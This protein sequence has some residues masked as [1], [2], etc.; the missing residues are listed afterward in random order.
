MSLYPADRV[1]KLVVSYN[2]VSE[3]S[4][5]GNELAK[6]DNVAGHLR[7]KLRLTAKHHNRMKDVR[8]QSRLGRYPALGMFLAARINSMRSL[9]DISTSSVIST[10]IGT[11]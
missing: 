1:H 7:S 10:R 9:I 8:I 5:I 11:Q 2:L 3:A 4:D 6:V